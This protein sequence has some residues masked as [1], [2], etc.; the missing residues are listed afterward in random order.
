MDCHLQ[1]PWDAKMCGRRKATHPFNLRFAMEKLRPADW[2]RMPSEIV[3]E[4]AFDSDGEQISDGDQDSNSDADS[5]THMKGNTNVVTRTFNYESP[6]FP[7]I[8]IARSKPKPC[9]TIS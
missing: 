8:S 3:H 7:F 5:G 9:H 4:D 1:C 6:S 2:F